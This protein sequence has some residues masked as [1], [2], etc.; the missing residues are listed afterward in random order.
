MA[1]A[2]NMQPYISSWPVQCHMETKHRAV[3]VYTHISDITRGGSTINRDRG[4]NHLPTIWNHL[5]PH[6]C[7][8]SWD[9]PLTL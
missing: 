5:L 4:T 3:T 6:G 1:L 2:V 7:I 9:Q 8:K